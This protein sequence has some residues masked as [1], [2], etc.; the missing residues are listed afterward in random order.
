MKSMKNVLTQ[1]NLEQLDKMFTFYVASSEQAERYVEVRSAAK[2]LGQRILE[3]APHSRERSL[4]MTKLE[5]VIMW[6]NKAIA[7]E[8]V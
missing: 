8:D 5:E 3:C 4:A 1:D 6:T 2:N 7:Q